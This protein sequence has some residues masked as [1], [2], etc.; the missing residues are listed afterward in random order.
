MP[1]QWIKPDLV[2]APGIGSG[3][4]GGH[5][6]VVR[7]SRF[8]TMF[9]ALDKSTA[10]PVT[11]AH[12]HLMAADHRHISKNFSTALSGRKALGF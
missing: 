4:N 5:P 7:K 6:G 2:P 3:W 10:Y 12:A 8:L 9:L 1:I 11:P